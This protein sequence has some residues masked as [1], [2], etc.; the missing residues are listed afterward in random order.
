MNKGNPIIL[1]SLGLTSMLAAFHWHHNYT[2]AAPNT[3]ATPTAISQTQ[4]IVTAANTFLHALNVE[5]LAKVQFSFTAQ[6]AATVARFKRSGENE[7]VP[8]APEDYARVNTSSHQQ[9]EGQPGPGNRPGGGPGGHPPQP[10]DKPGQGPGPGGP[11][12]GM[13]PAE[14]FVGEQYGQAV[15]SN[16][17][18]S[19]VLR[20]GLQLGSLNASQRKA[21]MHLLEV[22]LS[23]K[24][25]QKVLEIMGSDQVLFEGGTPFAS[26]INRYTIGIFGQPNTSTPWMIQFGG[27]HLGLNVV[28]AGAHGSSTPTLT[29]AQPAIYTAHGKTVRVLAGENDKAFTLLDALNDTQRKQAILNYHVDDLVLGPA[30]GGKT[31]VPEGLKASA[32]NA[33][34][35]TMLL[36]L[37]AEWTGIVND[38]YSKARMEDIKAGLEETYFAWSGPTTHQPGKNGSSYY[39]IQGPKL[40]IEFSPQGVG[41]DPTMHVH[42]IYR[43]P[44]NEYG[45]AFTGQ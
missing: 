43:D 34:Q 26:G 19:D 7:V 25:Y 6:K 36:D 13:G 8:F 29:G 42:T 40:V 35:R 2:H 5:Q 14:G 20:P 12:K 1:L 11:G 16:Y 3:M 27:H 37:I 39:R 45:H 15:W 30:S 9:H 4:A 32:M 41:G 31:I 10:G 24:G 38:A 21:A 28:I 33:Q 17:P 44:T 18:V 23:P 22:M